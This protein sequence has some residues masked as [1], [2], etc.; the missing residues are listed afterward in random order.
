MSISELYD[1]HCKLGEIIPPKDVLHRWAVPVG[2]HIKIVLPTIG[3]HVRPAN[4]CS[5]GTLA[6]DRQIAVNLPR[7]CAD[8]RAW[9]S[10]MWDILL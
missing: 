1:V 2:H 10:R 5:S 7:E 6:M 3:I 8:D 9:Q 4:N